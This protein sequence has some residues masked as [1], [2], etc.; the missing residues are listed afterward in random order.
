MNELITYG[1]FLGM[2]IYKILAGFMPDLRFKSDRW[3]SDGGGSSTTFTVF[4][5]SWTKPSKVIR[6]PCFSTR[7]YFLMG[8]SLTSIGATGLIQHTNRIEA[9]TTGVFAGILIASAALVFFAALFDRWDPELREAPVSV[10][11]D[12]LDPRESDSDE[13]YVV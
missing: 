11:D 6:G 9:L 10:Q 5:F 4:G 8:T 13:P 1:V 7:S 2:G 12:P 3:D